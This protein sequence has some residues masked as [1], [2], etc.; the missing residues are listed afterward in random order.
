MTALLNFAEYCTTPILYITVSII[1]QSAT[2][3]PVMNPINDTKSIMKTGIAFTAKMEE[4]HISVF[5]FNERFAMHYYSSN[6]TQPQYLLFHHSN[7][8][9]MHNT[10]TYGEIMIN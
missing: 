2:K 5:G 8:S 9:L 10:V 6:K 7:Y 4:P 3:Y 1:R